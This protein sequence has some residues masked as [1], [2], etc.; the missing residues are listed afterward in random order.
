MSQRETLLTVSYPIPYVRF[1]RISVY[2]YTAVMRA[3]C[4]RCMVN[5]ERKEQWKLP[6]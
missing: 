4:I 5:K 3:C 6:P 1:L 2:L